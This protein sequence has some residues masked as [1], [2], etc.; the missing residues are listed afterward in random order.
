M[1][2]RILLATLLLAGTTSAQVLFNETF[3]NNNAGWLVGAEW[4]IGP[5]TVSALPPTG[6]PD[7]GVDG[8]LIAGG[9]V[10]G[11][12]LGGTITTALHGFYYLESPAVDSSGAPSLYLEFDR[13]LNSDYPNYMHTIVEVFDGAN[14]VTIW[15]VPYPGIF[16]GS[17]N[18][19]SFDITA[20][21]NPGLKVRFGYSVNQI[22]S[23]TVTGWN[24]DNVV[25]RVGAR[26]QGLFEH[27]DSNSAG[28][29]LGNEWQIG[30]AVEYLSPTTGFGDPGHDGRYV[31]GGGLAGVIIGGNAPVALHDFYYLTSPAIDTSTVAVASLVYRRRLQT[32]Y[33][34]FMES[35]IDVFDGVGWINVYSNGNVGVYDPDWTT[36]FVDLTPYKNAWMRVRFGFRIG[37]LGAFNV[38]QWSLDEVKLGAF[39]AFTAIHGVPA[40]PFLTLAAPDPVLGQPWNLAGAGGPPQSA[41]VLLVGAAGPPITIAGSPC[42]IDVA[43][44]FGQVMPTD[45]AGSFNLPIFLP[46]APDLL[47]TEVTV[48]AA[49]IGPFGFATSNA[50]IIGFGNI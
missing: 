37:S 27:F 7:P 6:S 1:L 42:T 4:Q 5:A 31:P 9:G 33:L 2:R 13:W 16:D 36:G 49:Y 17:W 38:G 18:K 28:W 44:Q 45:G 25:L 41:T 40:L 11:A 35:T 22:G 39:D 12:V 15:A 32:D 23:Y 43:I 20:Y 24:V 10:A 48:Q 30:P 47:A 8:F 46:F 29:V 34:P 14:W 19:M 50:L 3:D 26:P 21:A